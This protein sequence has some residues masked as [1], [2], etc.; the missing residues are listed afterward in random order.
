MLGNVIKMFTFLESCEEMDIQ[1][2]IQTKYGV[3]CYAIIESENVL[4]YCFS[5]FFQI[6]VKI[7][8]AMTY[9]A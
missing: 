3:E 7:M 5:D 4:A 6:L 1:E 8:S 9:A 2:K